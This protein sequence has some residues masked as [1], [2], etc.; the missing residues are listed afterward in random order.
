M[1]GRYI[2]AGFWVKAQDFLMKFGVAL[3]L[4]GLTLFPVIMFIQTR[5]VALSY[6]VMGLS[7]VLMLY[8]IL[9][10]LVLDSFRM[11]GIPLIESRD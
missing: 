8:M 10:A 3:G 2:S 6:G 9:A 5:S 7:V 11:N 1:S 4:L